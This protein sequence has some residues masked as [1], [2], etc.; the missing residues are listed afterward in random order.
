MTKTVRA[1]EE[2]VN[3]IIFER[4]PRGVRL[5]SVG[6]LIFQRAQTVLADVQ[7]LQDEI[8]Q[9]AGQDGGQI[10]VGVSPVGGTVIMP[11]ALKQFRRKWPRVEVDL[12]NVLYPESVNLLREAALDIVIGPMPSLDKHGIVISEPLFD[13]DVVVATHE[14]NPRRYATSLA[15]LKDQQWIIHGPKEGPSSLY[16]GTFSGQEHGLPAAFT[17]CYSLSST[18]AMLAETNAFC[19]F[20]RQLFDSV[21]PSH[22]IVRVP[23]ADALPR[24]RLALVLQKTRPLTPA[25]AD[26]A[27][28][29]RRRATTLVHSGLSSDSLRE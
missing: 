18:V 5:T 12:I 23:V 1:L 20:S 15:E 4:T 9:L 11:R 19:V 21:A 6:E 7:A 10:R 29:I 16:S 24:F 2:D 8:S 28:H 13:M 26:L 27:N 17:R 3:V 14:S 22:G 25:A